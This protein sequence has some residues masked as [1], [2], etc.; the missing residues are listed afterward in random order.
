MLK[1]QD[2]QEVLVLVLIVGGQLGDLQITNTTISTVN[3]G[4]D[5]V[6]QP[7]TGIIDMDT[8]TALVFHGTNAE[9]QLA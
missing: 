8:D 2:T 5:I 4:D 6:L 9:R 1:V 3:S 7:S